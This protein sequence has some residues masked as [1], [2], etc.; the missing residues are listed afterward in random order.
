MSAF[1]EEERAALRRRL[2]EAAAE[3]RRVQAD[4]QLRKPIVDPAKWA[5]PIGMDSQGRLLPAPP[6]G[7]LDAYR[8]KRRKGH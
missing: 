2:D 4:P 3:R 8:R 6:Q 7:V 5:D 1:S